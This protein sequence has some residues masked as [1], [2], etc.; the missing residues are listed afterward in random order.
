M[1]IATVIVRWPA[2]RNELATREIDVSWEEVAVSSLVAVPGR[3][4][5]RWLG[6]LAA[7]HPRRHRRRLPSPMLRRAAFLRT[8]HR[9]CVL[10]TPHASASSSAA[11]DPHTV[12]GVAQG[13]SASELK[14]AYRDK[15]LVRHP[16]ALVGVATLAPE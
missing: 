11:R 13:A 15:A 5:A 9:P 1:S 6:D 12:L 4:S 7:G 8:P 10:R 3:L 14:Q 16:S 2:L